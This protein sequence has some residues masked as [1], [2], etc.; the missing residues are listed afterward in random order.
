MSGCVPGM[1]FQH[2]KHNATSDE[3]DTNSFLYFQILCLNFSE[4]G[5]HSMFW[6]CDADHGKERNLLFFITSKGKGYRHSEHSPVL[7]DNCHR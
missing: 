3:T 5:L 4:K 6:G 2:R 1:P 7:I